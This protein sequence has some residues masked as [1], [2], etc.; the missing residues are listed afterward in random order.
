MPSKLVCLLLTTVFVLL[1]LGVQMDCPA[2]TSL[3]SREPDAGLYTIQVGAFSSMERAG[4]LFRRL[5]GAGETASYG[6]VTVPGHGEWVRVLTGSFATPESARLYAAHLVTRGLIED[7]IIKPVQ[8][9]AT[10]LRRGSTTLSYAIPDKGASLPRGA[11]NWVAAPN[12]DHEKLVEGGGSSPLPLPLPISNI[13]GSD[14]LTLSS[15]GA[16]SAACSGPC[17]IPGADPVLGAFREI[18]G[19][20]Y[21]AGGGLWIAGDTSKGLADLR[22]IVGADNRDCLSVD[23]N[24][25]IRVDGRRLAAKAGATDPNPASAFAMLDYLYSN[26]GLL[27]LIQ[28]TSGRHRY[29]LDIDPRALTME[30]ETEVATALNLDNNFDSRISPIRKNGNKLARER[31]PVGFDSLVAI[32]PAA[33]WVNLNSRRTIIGPMIVF[34]ELAEAYAKV[35]LGLQYLPRGG[36]AGAHNTAI[37]R[38]TKLRSER[39]AMR[40]EGAAG[41]NRVFTSDR[42]LDRF[43][44]DFKNVAQSRRQ[45]A[46]STQ[47]ARPVDH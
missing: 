15:P 10:L 5:R 17:S 32:N 13:A 7:Y 8:K 44:E 35:E 20:A 31:P 37:E 9:P 30:G 11:L 18:S 22:W 14:V 16:G 39:S 29:R 23:E 27:L 3:E 41:P 28:L 36:I 47:A 26:N 34:H 6:S 4:T 46:S 25:M 19:Q 45:G 24:G 43:I 42:E 40:I 1:G 21:A 38:E 12:V 33:R 2:Q